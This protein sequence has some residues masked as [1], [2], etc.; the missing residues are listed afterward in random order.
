M[1]LTRKHPEIRN[2]NLPQKEKNFRWTTQELK[3]LVKTIQKL[4]KE[5]VKHVNK[6]A[7][8]LLPNRSEVAIQKIRTKQEYK[9]AETRINERKLIDVEDTPRKTQLSRIDIPISITRIP[10]VLP[11]VPPTPITGQRRRI[12]PQFLCYQLE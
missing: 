3:F 11:P 4:K 6:A 5:G 12:L 10:R 7:P 2:E 8:E 9:Q 1:H